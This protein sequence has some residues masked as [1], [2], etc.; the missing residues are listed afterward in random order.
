[1]LAEYY[2][3][4]RALHV[5]AVG[6]SVTLLLVRALIGLR[7]GPAAVPLP[8][9]ILPHAVDTALLASAVCLA[10]VMHQYPFV[11]GWLTAKF[12]ALCAY[13]VVGTVAVKRGRTP[14]VR[15]GALV[16]ALL[17]FAYIVG[18]ALRHDPAPWRW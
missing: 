16:G 3:Q 11:D 8:L 9:R 14:A 5:A 15:A 18:T 1:M 7:S 4:L 2:L 6:V 10:I 13:V 17:I 12:L